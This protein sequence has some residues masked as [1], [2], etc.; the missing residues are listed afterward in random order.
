[1]AQPVYA[2]AALAALVCA[3]LLLKA[4][5]E[6]VTL[7]RVEATLKDSCGQLQRALIENQARAANNG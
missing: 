2:A 4:Y 6:F 1:M 7:R 5:Y 3:F